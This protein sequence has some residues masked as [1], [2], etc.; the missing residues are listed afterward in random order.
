MAKT[1]SLHPRVYT[2]VAEIVSFIERDNPEKAHE[3]KDVFWSRF[4]YLAGSPFPV[5]SEYRTGHLIL[6]N[7][8]KFVIP[9]YRRRYLVFYRSLKSEIQILYLFEGSRNIP[10]RIV[11]DVRIL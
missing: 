5:G 10:A 11:D 2:D 9:E 1:L 4:E 6:K 7:L 3:V 8:R